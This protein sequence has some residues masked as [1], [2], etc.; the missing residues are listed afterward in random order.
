MGANRIGM[1]QRVILE[2]PAAP[3]D[4]GVLSGIRQVTTFDGVLIAI[5]GVNDASIRLQSVDGRVTSGFTAT[6]TV[7]KELAKLILEPVRVTGPATWARNE[8]GAWELERMQIQSWELLEDEPLGLI[9][10]R[11]RSANVDWPADAG[12]RLHAE[13]E[14]AE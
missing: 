7:A 5:G 10:E 3:E 13:R 9:L 14:G 2:I 8:D 1:E 6:R 12:T 11:L 4:T